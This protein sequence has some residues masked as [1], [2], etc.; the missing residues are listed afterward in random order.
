M[1]AGGNGYFVQVMAARGYCTVG[2][3]V[4]FISYRMV[5]TY[6]EWSHTWDNGGIDRKLR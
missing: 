5:V 3:I 2:I 1:T 4:D 6:S